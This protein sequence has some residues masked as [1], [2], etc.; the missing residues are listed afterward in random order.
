MPEPSEQNVE[1]M[2]QDIVAKFVELGKEPE[3]PKPPE[4]SPAPA[5][6]PEAPAQ[7]QE[8]Q[9]FNEP[10]SGL[11]EPAKE[12]WRK[13]RESTQARIDKSNSELEKV[14]KELESERKRIAEQQKSVVDLTEYEGLK[15]KAEEL[16]STVE[17]LDLENSPK[18]RNYFDG[19]IEKHIKLARAV[20]GTKADEVSRLLTQPRS[21]DR[22]EKLREIVDELGLDGGVILESLS[23]INKLKLERAEQLSNHRENVKLLRESESR[24]RKRQE[25]LTISTRQ[26]RADSVLEMIKT[27]PEFNPD[28]NDQEHK[29][30]VENA[31]KVIRQ[32]VM[33]ELPENDSV[34]M[35]PTAM[36]AIYF[37]KIRLPKMMKE[38]DALKARLA[39]YESSSPRTSSTQSKGD[40]TPTVDKDDPYGIAAMTKKFMEGT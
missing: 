25:E 11:S 10:P 34:L 7:P 8:K 23:G 29:A 13:F 37:E 9:E 14:R 35:A 33:G 1:K 5:Q 39:E 36:K 20:A 3:P 26:S 16:E 19:G 6:P 40:S 32:A 18:F 4:P 30:F 31:V 12:S 27:I 15:K 21:A 24:E 17:R 2:E 28:P 38:I 22:D